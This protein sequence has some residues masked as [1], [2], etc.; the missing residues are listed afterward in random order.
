MFTPL[1]RT[2]IMQLHSATAAAAVNL[3]L[4]KQTTAPVILRLQK[5]ATKQ[6]WI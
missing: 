4:Q 5:Q 6:H 2:S 1:K 3:L